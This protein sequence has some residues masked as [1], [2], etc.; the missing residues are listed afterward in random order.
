MHVKLNTYHWGIQWNKV[1]ML[2]KKA[3]FWRMGSGGKGRT[4]NRGMYQVKDGLD[5]GKYHI[6]YLHGKYTKKAAADRQ[7]D[8]KIVPGETTECCSVSEISI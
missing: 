3:T 4:E 6:L 8:D 2:V 5:H 7:S 1:V